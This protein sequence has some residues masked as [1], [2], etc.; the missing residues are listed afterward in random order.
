MIKDGRYYLVHCTWNSTVVDLEPSW[1]IVKWGVPNGFSDIHG[2]EA[3]VEHNGFALRSDNC[4]FGEFFE[5]DSAIALL[6]CTKM[7]GIDY[8]KSKS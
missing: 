1:V 8:G 4:T 3:W 7:A 2:Q 5:L 6:R